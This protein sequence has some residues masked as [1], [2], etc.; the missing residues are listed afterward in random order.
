MYD[1]GSNTGESISNI[2]EALV[3]G[4]NPGSP[5]AVITAGSGGLHRLYNQSSLGTVNVTPVTVNG[6]VEVRG[7]PVSFLGHDVN[8]SLLPGSYRVV[9]SNGSFPIASAGVTL[10]AGKYV[11]LVL[12]TASA[13]VSQGAAGAHVNVT[14]HDFA[15]ASY[16]TVSLA[17]LTSTL[18]DANTSSAG[19]FN[20]TLTVPKVAAG[21]YALT[22]TDG[23]SA[24]DAASVPFQVTTDLH[25]SVNVSPPRTDAGLPV[26]FTATPYGGFGPYAL[27]NWSFGDGTNGATTTPTTT[28]RYS[29]GG[30][31]AAVARVTDSVGSVANVSFEVFV[32]DLPRVSS[33]TASPPSADV[34][35]SVTFAAAAS[36]GTPPYTAYQWSGLPIGCSPSNTDLLNC[37]F[38]QSG[39]FRLDVTVTDSLGATSTVSGVL[40]YTVYA[41]PS[42]STPTASPSNVD[43]GQVVRFQVSGTNGSGTPQYTW[44]GLPFGCS[45]TT[46][47]LE[48]APAQSGIFHLSAGVRDSNGVQVN[49]T[50]ALAFTVYPDP[51][52]P[53]APTVSSP[54]AD[55]GEPLTLSAPASGDR[56]GTPTNGAVY[57]PAA[58]PRTRA[59]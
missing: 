44:F 22:A 9:Q 12:P 38:Q 40:D 10:G 37:T 31:F 53:A 30:T 57:R 20:C 26:D 13:S 5:G 42:V 58:C 11:H 54:S 8:L 4:T 19:W 3:S 25:V 21:H 7:V 50:G 35:Q 15:S 43:V 41:D 46:D 24:A 34:H 47:P 14:G 29:N 56:E 6:T 52:L 39:H 1:F 51:S 17:P 55:V 16:L 45:G 33:L 28:H 48:C 49:G 59:P 32:N 23:S 2:Q 36:L 27:Y 18:C